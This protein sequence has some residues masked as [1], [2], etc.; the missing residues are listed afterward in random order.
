[1]ESKKRIFADLLRIAKIVDSVMLVRGHDVDDIVS[2]LLNM[3]SKRCKQIRTNCT[4]SSAEV[5]HLIQVGFSF[6]TDLKKKDEI[7]DISFSL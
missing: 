3:Y 5:D 2:I 1:M 7:N 4:L 6:F